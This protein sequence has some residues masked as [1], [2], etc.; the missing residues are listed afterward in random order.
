MS[1]QKL[2]VALTGLNAHDNPG[3][4]IP[5][6][7][8]LRDSDAFDLRIIGF[9]YENMEPGIYLKDVDKTYLVPYPQDGTEVLI[10]RLAYI[11]EIEKID[12]IIPNYDAELYNYMKISDLLENLGIKTFLPTLEQFE[13]RHKHNLPEY[14]K[15]YGLLIPD[16]KAITNPK[17]LEDLAKEYKFP[18]V[19]KGKY[20]DAHIAHNLE[21]AQIY[22]QK[23]AA[24]WGLPI[25][26]QKFIKGTEV[27]VAALG[28]GN[29]NTIAAVPMKK[30]YITDK[31]KAWS[32]ITLDDDSMIELTHKIMR[33]TKWRSAFELELIKDENGDLYIVEINPRI[34]A[35]IYLTHGAGQ[36]IPKALV[37]L[38][39]GN[40]V[41]PYPKHKVGIMFIRYS[42]DIITDVSEFQKVV[43]NGEY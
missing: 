27:N 23:I 7:R 13:E 15:K 28:D 16:S 3:P 14:G 43:I 8:C 39:L 9:A 6:V 41:K 29:G 40:E 38:V 18:L 4:G 2:T 35:W 12:I 17:D 10:N 36:N 24:K 22:F 30:I 20:Y 26:V 21:Q 32:G 1:K 11:N 31:G 37:D 5:V 42:Y 25:I 34:P 19:I 33:E